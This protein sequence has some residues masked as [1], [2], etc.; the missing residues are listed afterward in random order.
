MLDDSVLRCLTP[1]KC[2]GKFSEQIFDAVRNGDEFLI[3]LRWGTDGER[4]GNTP[5]EFVLMDAAD[6]TVES[7]PSQNYELKSSTGIDFD[8]ATTTD[9]ESGTGRFYQRPPKT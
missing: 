7:D 3:V 1:V 5:K 9:L 8:A 6:I 4:E 2:D